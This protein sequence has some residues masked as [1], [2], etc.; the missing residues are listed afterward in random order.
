MSALYSR[1]QKWRRIPIVKPYFSIYDYLISGSHDGL[2][3]EIPKTNS[4]IFPFYKVFDSVFRA[5]SSTS[6]LNYEKNKHNPKKV[7]FSNCV[8]V[9]L[10]ASRQEY[11]DSGIKKNLWYLD[12]DFTSFKLDRIHEKKMI[13]SIENSSK[14]V[15]NDDIAI[16]NNDEISAN[17]VHDTN[18]LNENLASFSNDKIINEEK[19]FGI[20][21]SNS[22]ICLNLVERG[23]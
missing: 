1:K 9:I 5:W 23:S 19:I 2:E 10:I 12:E 13:T 22:V 17:D 7:T 11:I 6:D 21:R 18:P 16:E 20:I 15:N 14:I 8:K 3:E 4:D